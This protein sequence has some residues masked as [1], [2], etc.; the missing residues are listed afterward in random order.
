M[1]VRPHGKNSPN[2]FSRH[3]KPG[4]PVDGVKKRQ[5]KTMCATYHACFSLYMCT[6]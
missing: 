4:H 3:L 5:I 2:K 6:F 1:Q